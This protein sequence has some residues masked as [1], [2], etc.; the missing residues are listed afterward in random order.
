MGSGKFRG[1]SIKTQD[2]F[3]GLKEHTERARSRN[4]ELYRDDD[5]P[6]Y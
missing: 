4:L 5:L 1:F 6:V 2:F 3:A